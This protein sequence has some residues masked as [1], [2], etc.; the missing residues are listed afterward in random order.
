MLPGRF[1]ICTCLFVEVSTIPSQE[2]G[3]SDFTEIMRYSIFSDFKNSRIFIDGAFFEEVT[4]EFLLMSN[5]N[6]SFV[7]L[8]TVLLAKKNVV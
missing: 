2:L 5:K 3:E 1:A 6:L 4:R 7:D 8:S